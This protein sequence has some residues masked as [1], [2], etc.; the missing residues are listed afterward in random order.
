MG[1]PGSGRYRADTATPSASQPQVARSATP[2][3][4]HP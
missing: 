1:L 4:I 3:R 2:A